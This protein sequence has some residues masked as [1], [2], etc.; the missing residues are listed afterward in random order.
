MGT[1]QTGQLGHSADMNGIAI[2]TVVGN[3][4]NVLRAINMASGMVNLLFEVTRLD[5]WC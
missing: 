1:H 3:W 4:H 5:L 2:A